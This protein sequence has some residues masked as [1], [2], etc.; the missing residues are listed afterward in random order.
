MPS[1]NETLSEQRMSRAQ[2]QGM[3]STIYDIRRKPPPSKNQIIEKKVDKPFPFISGSQYK[4]E[5]LNDKKH[6]FGIQI[7]PDNTKYEGDWEDDTYTGRGTLWI[8]KTK[9][10]SDNGSYV[11]QYVGSWYRNKRHGQGIFYYDNGEI[12]R[13]EWENNLRCGQGKFE[14]KNGDIYNGN[15]YND[16]KHGHGIMSYSNGNIYDGTWYEDKKEGKG[17]YYYASTKKVS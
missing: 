10:I 4:G 15:Y 3:H 5:W 1:H 12:Y 14:S 16:M 17:I 9:K 8:K 11:R 13:G 6:G 2:R 7:N